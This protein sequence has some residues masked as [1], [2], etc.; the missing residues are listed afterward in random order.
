MLLVAYLDMQS[1]RGRDLNGGDYSLLDPMI[2][3]SDNNAASTVLG[4]VGPGR[5]DGVAR[6]AGMTQFSVQSPWGL[7]HITASDQT[8]FFLHIDSFIASRHVAY[9]LH[10]LASITPSQRWG[11]G[12][13]KPRGWALYFKGGWGSGTGAVDHQVALLQRG[14]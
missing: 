3:F 7:S 13:V 14:C 9:A 11:I 12:E 5:L 2:E 1:V 4:I 6:M 10:L 8:K